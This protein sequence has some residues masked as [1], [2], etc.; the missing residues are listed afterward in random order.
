M[1]LKETMWWKAGR[2]RATQ[3]A[4][5]KESGNPILSGILFPQLTVSCVGLMQQP[6]TVTRHIAPPKSGTAAFGK[7][8]K[9]DAECEQNK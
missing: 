5:D 9:S 8:T 3:K 1:G 2:A 6:S 4:L 7:K